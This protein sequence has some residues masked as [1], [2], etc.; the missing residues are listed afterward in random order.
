MQLNRRVQVLV[1]RNHLEILHHRR[2]AIFQIKGGA[3]GVQHV[4]ASHIKSVVVLVKVLPGRAT[5]A[6]VAHAAG[7]QARAGERRC[8]E[9]RGEIGPARLGHGSRTSDGSDRIHAA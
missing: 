4:H 9:R 2:Q 8:R 5:G 3:A 6:G 7:I 1:L